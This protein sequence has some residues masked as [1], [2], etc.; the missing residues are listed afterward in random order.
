MTID[1]PNKLIL[2]MR[3][4]FWM[5]FR[6][7]GAGAADFVAVFRN[8]GIPNRYFP[9]VGGWLVLGGPWRWDAV[10][11]EAAITKNH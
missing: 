2:D 3:A 11:Y 7:S 5:I 10:V 8:G 6:G 4:C 9:G 1:E